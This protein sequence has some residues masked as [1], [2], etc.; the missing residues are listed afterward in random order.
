ME[1]LLSLL[2]HISLECTPVDACNGDRISRKVCAAS[3][4]R[5]QHSRNCIDHPATSFCNRVNAQIQQLYLT[6]TVSLEFLNFREM[7]RT[8]AVILSIFR[9]EARLVEARPQPTRAKG[10]DSTVQLLSTTGIVDTIVVILERLST[11]RI[12]YI[13]GEFPICEG[14][15]VTGT[16]PGTNGPVATD[17]LLQSYFT[18]FR[19]IEVHWRSEVDDLES[20]VSRGQVDLQISSIV[21]GLIA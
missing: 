9:L 21:F 15:V 1:C 6:P 5:V 3:W 16:P 12:A 2:F 7:L 4:K 13:I 18:R 20:L 19:Q 14:F 11:S 10:R 8:I 17:W